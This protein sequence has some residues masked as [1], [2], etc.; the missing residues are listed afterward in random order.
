[1]SIC[2]INPQRGK[3]D[4]H[5]PPCG[6]LAVNPADSS[7]FANTAKRHSLEKQFLFNAQLFSNPHF[8]LA[9]PAVGAPMATLCLEKLIALGARRVVVYGWCG[10]LSRKL[11]IGDVFVPTDGLSEEGVSRH[12]PAPEGWSENAL[13]LC[14]EEDLLRMGHRPQHGPIWTT[15]AVYRETR[16]KVDLYGGQGFMAVDME[17]TALRAVAAFRQVSLAAAMLVSDELFH[18]Q[19][20]P[21]FLQKK[22]R[23]QSHRLLADLCSTF[24]PIETP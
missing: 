14:L 7:S 2:V 21:Q 4:P 9:G 6:I 10:S 15:D 8:F 5:L 3:S 23:T 17:Y 22:F 12:Y 20:T 16:E 11:R 18:P 13:R 19:W 1:M 24:H